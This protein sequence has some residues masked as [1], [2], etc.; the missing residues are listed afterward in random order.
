MLSPKVIRDDGA[1]LLEA[2]FA[3]EVG[4]DAPSNTAEVAAI[5]IDENFI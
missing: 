4:V 2:S 1:G 3:A 5:L